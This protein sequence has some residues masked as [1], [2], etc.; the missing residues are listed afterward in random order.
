MLFYATDDDRA[1]SVVE[2][3]ISAAGFDPLRAGGVEEAIQI[4]MFGAL[5]QYGGLNGGLLNLD[6]ARAALAGSAGATSEQAR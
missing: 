4:E 1:A 6:E 3:L 5:H 2:R